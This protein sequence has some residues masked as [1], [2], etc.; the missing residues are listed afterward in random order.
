MQPALDDIMLA[1]THTIMA[2][3]RHRLRGVKQAVTN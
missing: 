3:Q 1:M 2:G